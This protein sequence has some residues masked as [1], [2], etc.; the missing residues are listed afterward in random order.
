M[1]NVRNTE[2][3]SVSSSY[4]GNHRC[5]RVPEESG[6]RK[7]GALIRFLGLAYCWIVKAVN[8]SVNLSGQPAGWNLR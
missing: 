2:Y 6:V 1:I 4:L 8:V 7:E 3:D 5:N